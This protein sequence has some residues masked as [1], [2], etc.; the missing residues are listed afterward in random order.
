MQQNIIDACYN[1]VKSGVKGLEKEPLSRGRL[2]GK[3][4]R[5][6]TEGQSPAFFP[7]CALDYAVSALARNRIHVQ[8]QYKTPLDR[9]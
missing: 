9:N 8:S 7:I 6:G 2:R 1:G 3:L 4:E 5:N